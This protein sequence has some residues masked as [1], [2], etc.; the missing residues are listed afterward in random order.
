[1]CAHNDIFCSMKG[2][3]GAMGTSNRIIF[4]SLMNGMSKR[5][6]KIGNALGSIGRY[7]SIYLISFYIP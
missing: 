6:S 2:Y 4:N 1:M 5:G 3:R 7:V